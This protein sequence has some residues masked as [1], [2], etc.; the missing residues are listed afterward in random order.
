[1]STTNVMSVS[2]QAAAPAKVPDSK[3]GSRTGKKTNAADDS[4]DEAL[5]KANTD[6]KQ[7]AGDVSADTK[8]SKDDKD[9]KD[10]NPKNPLAA[11]LAALQQGNGKNEGSKTELAQPQL[12]GEPATVLAISDT[13]KGQF[14][15]TA[16]AAAAVQSNLQSLIPQAA[17]D[18][19]KSQ[20]F[21]AMLSGQQLKGAKQQGQVPL[22]QG[23][24]L[25]AA[26]PAAQT[27]QAPLTN[28]QKGTVVQQAAGTVLEAQLVNTQTAGSQNPPQSGLATGTPVVQPKMESVAG[29]TA[30]P[31]QSGLVAGA[32]AA[33]A[34][35]AQALAVQAPV[36]Q[37][38]PA[39]QALAVQAPAGADLVAQAAGSTNLPQTAQAPAA[40]K[41]SEGP[42]S[43]KDLLDGAPLAIEDKTQTAP[44]HIEG[45]KSMNQPGSQSQ[46]NGQGAAQHQTL[47]SGDG[48]KL[49]QQLPEEAAADR[50]PVSKTPDNAQNSSV[51]MFQQG[52]QDSIRGT[53]AN[54]LQSSQP[55]PA[56]NDYN[57]PRQIVDQARLIRTNENTEMVIKLNPEHLGE[58]TLKVSVSQNGSVNASFHS[59]NAQVRTAIE[60]SLVQLRQELNNQG[61]KVDSVEVYA[62]L[63]DGQLPQDQGQQ[64][65][66]NNQQGGTAKI[67]NVQLGADEYNEDTEV[68]SAVLQSKENTAMEGVDYR[69]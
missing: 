17:A 45:Q 2:S 4:F 28:D 18:G 59:E 60:N 19:V 49:A 63:A 6:S 48:I 30:V 68:L 9:S 21:L 35:A 64:A 62:G 8:G 14:V 25:E 44:L 10:E 65:W 61:L 58:L 33:Q 53:A 20:D 23:N 13:A 40:A 3:A 39:A 12:A 29:G 16:Q 27:M 32:P 34:P 43:V 52:L 50:A 47:L 54:H 38:A 51:S 69:I 1:M 15:N 26:V 37:Q 24:L 7:A 5:G 41:L 56:Q 67:R 11:I 36:A 66:Q 55:Q 22:M 46:Q 42:V 57:I 31:P